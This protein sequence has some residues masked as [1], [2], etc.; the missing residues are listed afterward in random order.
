MSDTRFTILGIVLIF[1]GFIVLGTL[2]GEHQTSSIEAEE[3]GDCYIYSDDAAPI[4]TDCSIRILDQT[5]FFG[6]V[7]ALIVAGV[8]FLI[9]GIRGKWDNEVKPEDMVGPGGGSSEKDSPNN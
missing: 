6:I 9:K 1:V 7:I 3:F 8:I 2:G 4:K 5:V